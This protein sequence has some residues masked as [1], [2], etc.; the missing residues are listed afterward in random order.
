MITLIEARNFRMLRYI[1]QPLDAFH[2]LVGPNASGKTTFLDVISFLGDIVSTDIDTAIRKRS[3]NYYDLTFNGE[4]GA[5]E[6]AVEALIPTEIRAALWNPAADTIRYEVRVAFDP[7]RQEH[8]LVT[9]RIYLFAAAEASVLDAEAPSTELPLPET[10]IRRVFGDT[11]RKLDENS[12]R[13]TLWRYSVGG[14]GL[15]SE[16]PFAKESGADKRLLSLNFQDKKRSLVHTL[17]ALYHRSEV[18]A[19]FWLIDLLTRNIRPLSIEGHRLRNP[20]APGQG[21]AFLPD[22]SNLPWV[23]AALRQEDERRFQYWLDH[24]RTALPDIADIRTV[25]RPEDR[26]RY[27]VIQYANGAAV[28]SWLVSDG[29]LRLLALTLTAY[30]RGFTGIYL[31]EDPENG[32]HPLALETVY[33]SLSSVYDAQLLLATHSPVVLGLVKTREILCF[34]KTAENTAAIVR[35]DQH[36]ALQDWKGSISLSTLFAS[37]VLE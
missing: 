5:I 36:P 1:R 30:V 16:M 12:H 8:Q 13:P 35:G 26:F 15:Q 3:P 6:L 4:G 17:A 37:G 10:I 28:P 32:I 2:V 31:L 27:L 29:T 25:E 7:K 20:S 23:I 14:V 33:H 18:P 9:E 11:R 19:T 34:T 24:L 21:V 22:G